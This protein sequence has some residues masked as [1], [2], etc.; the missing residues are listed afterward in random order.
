[1]PKGMFRSG[2]P[3]G[4]NLLR[5]RLLILRLKLLFC[6]LITKPINFTPSLCAGAHPI[7]LAAKA[8]LLICYQIMPLA[9]PLICVLDN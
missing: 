2:F 6:L 8:Q 3:P 1:M 5:S 4:I 9:R 7:M